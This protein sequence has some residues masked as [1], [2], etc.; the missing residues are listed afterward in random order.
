VLK[1]YGEDFRSLVLIQRQ[2]GLHSKDGLYGSLR[3]AVHGVESLVKEAGD[4]HL[5]N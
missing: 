1:T 2:I 3:K 4:Y 5:F